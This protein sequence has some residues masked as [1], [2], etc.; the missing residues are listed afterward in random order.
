MLSFSLYTHPT[1]LTLQ[2]S[3]MLYKTNG[4]VH[5]LTAC[6]K[7]WPC[8][9]QELSRTSHS[10]INN[11]QQSVQVQ[12]IKPTARAG[13]SQS[14]ISYYSHNAASVAVETSR[15]CWH[16][17]K[18][19]LKWGKMKLLHRSTWTSLAVATLSS[20]CGGLWASAV[21]QTG[22]TSTKAPPKYSM[23]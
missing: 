9:C 22:V 3:I 14:Q 1:H 13:Q 17:R 20:T 21:A 12:C 5:S 8:F 23:V 19:Q 7:D 16:H 10:H 18:V 2:H 4:T 11:Q 6:S 15:L